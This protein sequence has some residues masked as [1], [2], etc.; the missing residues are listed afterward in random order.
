MTGA[1]GQLMRGHSREERL[2]QSATRLPILVV[3]R[4]AFLEIGGGD[5]AG[6][7]LGVG[8]HQLRG[9]EQVL[10]LLG[11]RLGAERLPAEF[12][13]HAVGREHRLQRHVLLR[14]SRRAAANDEKLPLPRQLV[15]AEDPEEEPQVVPADLEDLTFQLLPGQV[16][17]EGDLHHEGVDHP[18]ASRSRREATRSAR[19]FKR[20]MVI[21]WPFSSAS[22]VIGEVIVFPAEPA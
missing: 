8:D 22:S 13:S 10:A 19:A 9:F 11:T 2:G 17:V 16:G 3:D 20:R 21:R 6:D 12:R 18:A 14:P 4:L 1:L 15:L 5:G 7:D